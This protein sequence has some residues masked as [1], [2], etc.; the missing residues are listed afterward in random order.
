M[1]Q[2]KVAG[3]VAKK[4]KQPNM[5]GARKKENEDLI[6]GSEQDDFGALDKDALNA[7]GRRF[8][9]ASTREQGECAA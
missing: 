5:A 8:V 6:Q 7:A 1:A 4:P 2:V 9:K 3:T